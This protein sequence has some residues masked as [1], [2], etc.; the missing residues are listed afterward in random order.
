MNRPTTKQELLKQA[1]ANFNKLMDIINNLDEEVKLATFSFEDRDRNI[2]DVLIHLYEWN[3]LLI[4]WI[5]SNTSGAA[6]SFLPQPYNWSNYP[7]L[8]LI[9]VQKHKDTLFQDA[10]DDFTKS[11]LEAMDLINILTNEELFEKKHFNW[12]EDSSVGEFCIET[13]SNHYNWAITK[14][15]KHITTYNS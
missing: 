8:N 1:T 2:K 4:N 11:H 13:T 14:I 6:I 9:F 5:R 10:Y 3:E 7:D 12:T 15:N